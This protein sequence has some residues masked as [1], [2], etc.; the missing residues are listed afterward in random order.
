MKV[1]EIVTNEQLE[2]V[3]GHAN[4][5]SADKREVLAFGLLQTACGYHTGGTVRSIM[6]D[7]R[8]IGDR[9]DRFAVPNLRKRGREYLWAAFG[10]KSF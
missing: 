3:S 4:F 6:E 2:K 10:R 7:L 1:E 9:K 5:G 8:L